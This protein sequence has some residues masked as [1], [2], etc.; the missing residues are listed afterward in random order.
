MKKMQTGSL[1]I[2][3]SKLENLFSTFNEKF[4]NNELDK[5]VITVSPE[6]TK[7]LMVGVPHGGLGNRAKIQKVIM[8]SICVLNI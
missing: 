2:V 8:K 5:P 1:H 4:F 6:T 3:I 7:V